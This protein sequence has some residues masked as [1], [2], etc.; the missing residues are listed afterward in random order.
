MACVCPSLSVSVKIR[1]L[2]SGTFPKQQTL[3]ILTGTS[4]VETCYELSLR[5]VDAQIVIN[6]TVVGQIS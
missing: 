2:P 6:W 5:K 4:I 3:K 1:V